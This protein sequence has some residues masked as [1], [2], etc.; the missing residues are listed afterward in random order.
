MQIKI[1]NKEYTLYFG[2]EFL[3]QIN[4]KFGLKVEAEG[5]DINTR[6]AGLPFMQ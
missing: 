3:D 1:A 4:N 5:Q 2:W 6:S